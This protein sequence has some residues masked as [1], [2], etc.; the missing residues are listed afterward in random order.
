MRPSTIPACTRAVSGDTATGDNRHREAA[1]FPTKCTN[2]RSNG[3]S[4]VRTVVRHL[5]SQKWIAN[6]EHVRP[7][8]RAADRHVFLHFEKP[9]ETR[10]EAAWRAGQLCTHTAHAAHAASVTLLMCT[11]QSPL[12]RGRLHLN[13]RRFLRHRAARLLRWD[14]CRCS[15]PATQRHAYTSAPGGIAHPSPLADTILTTL[16]LY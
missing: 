3:M 14:H 13:K 11:P 5:V 15:L 4:A 6:Q 9:M 12:A 1:T 2:T 7:V 10:A 16:R 8:R